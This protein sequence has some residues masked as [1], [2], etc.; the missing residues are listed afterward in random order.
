LNESNVL[1]TP[2]AL[3]TLVDA[4]SFQVPGPG[5]V[6]RCRVGKP[7]FTPPE[8]Q[9]AP[10]ADVDRGPE[11]DAFALGVLVFQ[12]LMQGLHPFAGMFTGEGEP[13][14]LPVRIAA[15]FWPYAWERP[16]PFQPIPYAPPWAVLPPPVQELFFACF[17]EG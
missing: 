15:G 7:E 2:Q 11:H 9:G 17:E 14:P 10:F 6:Y 4:D 3:V 12:L 16:G 8:L 13:D 5:R 1:V